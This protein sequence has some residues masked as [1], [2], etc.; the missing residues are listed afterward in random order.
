MKGG[1]SGVEGRMRALYYG[2]EK[3]KEGDRRKKKGGKRKE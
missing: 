3:E 1:K 2:R